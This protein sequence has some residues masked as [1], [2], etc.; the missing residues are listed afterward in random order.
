MRPLILTLALL[1]VQAHAALRPG[2]GSG[3]TPKP[4]APPT[5]PVPPPTGG[6]SPTTVC[7][8]WPVVCV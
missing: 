2:T 3:T 6:G 8:L 5:N 7:V 1:S 4:T